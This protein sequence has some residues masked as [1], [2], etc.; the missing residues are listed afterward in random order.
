MPRPAVGGVG[1]SLPDDGAKTLGPP[2]V[3]LRSQEIQSQRRYRQTPE[4]KVQSRGWGQRQDGKCVS[5]D[6]LQGEGILLREPLSSEIIGY[7][8]G[9][10]A[11]AFSPVEAVGALDPAQK[12]DVQAMGADVSKRQVAVG[13]GSDYRAEGVENSAT[14]PPMLTKAQAETQPLGAD[15][16]LLAIQLAG[17]TGSIAPLN[18]SR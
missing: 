6:W 9:S 11:M 10:V 17:P 18:L 4:E 15:Q 7:N 1:S 3:A 14:I 12:G 5:Q 2:V 13:G 8:V 16:K